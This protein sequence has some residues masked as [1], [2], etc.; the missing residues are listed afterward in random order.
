[1][2][3]SV[4]NLDFGY[5]G[6]AIGRNVSFGLAGGEVLCLL[7]PNG[8]GKTTLFKTVLGLIPAQGGRVTLDGNAIGA[9]SNRE[10]AQCMGYVPQAHAALFPFSVRDIV[11][12]GRAARL[13]ALEAPGARDHE[14]AQTAL[15]ALGVAELAERP[16]TEISGGERQIVLIAR[17]LAQ[18]PQLLVMDEPTASLDYGNQ[19]R[20]LAHIRRLAERGI[21]VIISTHNPDHAFLCADHVALLHDGRMEAFGAPEEVLTTAALKKLYDIDV[22]IGT[23]DGSSAKVCAPILGEN[24]KTAAR[25][26][27]IAHDGP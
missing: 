6:T 14:A 18:E 25:K 20:V 22:V 17:A 19:M 11:L 8:A 3:L 24:L 1:M 15:A 9:L 2:K 13:S 5:G 26:Q 7:G 23:V 4:E 12:M 10:R 16:Y 21:A 27:E